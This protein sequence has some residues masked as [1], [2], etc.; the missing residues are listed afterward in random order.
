[1]I[2]ISLENKRKIRLWKE[3]FTNKLSAENHIAC[4]DTLE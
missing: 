1:M 2:H 3:L 4:K